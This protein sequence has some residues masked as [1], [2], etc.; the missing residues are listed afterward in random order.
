MNENIEQ[1]TLPIYDN[2]DFKV[3]SYFVLASRQ[4]IN[5]NKNLFEKLESY[6][7]K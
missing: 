4:L 5:Q 6:Q 1:L 2:T 7:E 3:F